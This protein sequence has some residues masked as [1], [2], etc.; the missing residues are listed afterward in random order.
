[1]R[2][3]RMITRVALAALLLAGCSVFK[4]DADKGQVIFSHTLHSEQADCSDCHEGIADNGGRPAGKLIPKGHEG[5]ENCHEVDKKCDQCHRGAREGVQLERVDRK[6]NFSHKAHMARVK[7]CARCHPKQ[8][9]GGG[10]IPG[11]ATCNTAECHAKRY[12]VLECRSCHRDLHRYGRQPPARLTHG[13]GFNRSHGALA[14]Q[15]VRACTQCHDQTFCA[16]CHAATT[17][18]RASVRFPE[19]VESGFIHRGDFLTRHAIEARAAPQ[20]CRR[21]H[22]QRHCRSCHTLNG[23]APAHVGLQGGGQRRSGVHPSGWMTVGS[24]DFHGTKARLDIGRCASC[25]DQGANSNCV[26]CHRVGGMGG[27]PH[28]SGWSWRDKSSQCQNTPMCRIC[29]SAGQ[30]CQ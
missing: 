9:H 2:R 30:G 14:R 7:E 24:G 13:P 25:H 4:G 6:L 17:L 26:N 20:S 1:M 19:K 5:C 16:D 11:H 8:Q 21:C 3:Q 27:N 28:P 23:L 18:E 15:S 10:V 22:G 29:H 12:K